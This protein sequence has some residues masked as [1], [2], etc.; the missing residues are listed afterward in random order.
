MKSTGLLS[1][2]ALLFGGC[3]HHVGFHSSHLGFYTEPEYAQPGAVPCYGTAPLKYTIYYGSDAEWHY[4]ESQHDLKFE[5]YKV[6]RW[7]LAWEPV[8]PVRKGRLYVERD[9]EGRLQAILPVEKRS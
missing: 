3:A 2:A 9:R 6:P 7:S 8:F 5:R 4:F 1:L